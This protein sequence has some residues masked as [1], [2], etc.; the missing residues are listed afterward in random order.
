MKPISLSILLMVLA[1]CASTG[2]SWPQYMGPNRDGTVAA[3]NLFGDEVSLE[4]LWIQPLG[5]GFSGVVV[6]DGRLY[7]MHTAGDMD[8]LSCF[9][10]GTGKKRWSF[11][12]GA[13]F[14]KVGSSE[15]GPLSTPVLDGN[16]VYGLGAQGE[17]FCLEASSG[18]LVWARNIVKELGAVP[19]E[20]GIASSPLV[21][22]DLLILN[23][24]DRKDKSIAAF[25]KDTGV[26][27]WHMGD[28][29]ISFQSPA[30]LKLKGRKQVV[31]LSE[32]RMRGI[33]PSTGKVIW[34]NDGKEWIQ[35]IAIGDD[36]MLSGHYH[37]LILH[38]LDSS[39]GYIKLIEKWNNSHLTVEYNMPVHHNGY[40]YG[41]K[42]DFLTCL[43]ITTGEKVWS[44]R[45]AGR[46]GM[47]ILA[48][49]HLG[50]INPDGTFRV[51]RVSEKGYEE[52]ASIKVFEKSGI[53]APSY[54]DGVFY[55]RN[56]TH[57]A[58]VRVK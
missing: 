7:T 6:G 36:L 37:G 27:A 34:E 40:L 25:N 50:T 33:D 26:L 44:S 55:M 8:A 41:F 5:S 42:G 15:P 51:G 19:R 58:A 1:G 12:Y 13:S 17:L 49:G 14:P 53:T 3:P 16:R 9:H 28:E 45:N 39:A 24:G 31:S 30:L 56:Y 21:S 22:G 46:R 52:R 18:K 47:A 10:A 38:R 29:K 57:L 35:I 4:R 2:E 11:E 48:D 54:A 32:T 43:N 20:V 23:V